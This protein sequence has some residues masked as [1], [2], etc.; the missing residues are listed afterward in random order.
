MSH[1]HEYKLVGHGFN[2]HGNFD[3]ERCAKCGDEKK[4]YTKVNKKPE[5]EDDAK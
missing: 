3:V 5:E 1:R 2:D 4:S